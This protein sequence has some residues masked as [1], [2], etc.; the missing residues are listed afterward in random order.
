MKRP[1]ELLSVAALGLLTCVAV[2]A[3]D[4][5]GAT[6]SAAP[7]NTARNTVDRDGHTTTPMDQSNDETSTRITASI[8][9]AVMEDKSLSTDAHNVKIVT[10]AN[11]VTIRGPVAS[12]AEKKRIESLAEKS[13][14]GRQIQNELSVAG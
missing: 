5:T 1:Y 12:A 14:A 8:R 4:S 9:R 13:A 3:Q 10:N 11:T 6:K 2:N 7:D